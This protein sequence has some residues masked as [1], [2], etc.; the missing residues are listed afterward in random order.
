MPSIYS[1]KVPV[2]GTE[3]HTCEFYGAPGLFWT[4]WFNYPTSAAT[5]H[6]VWRSIWAS[7]VYR[8]TVHSIKHFSYC[9]VDPTGM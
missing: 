1:G 4:F 5:S 6:V 3:V 7:T 8:A 9:Y 2:S